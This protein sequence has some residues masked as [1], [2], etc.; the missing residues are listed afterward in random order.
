MVS[1][2]REYFLFF[3]GI[4]IHALS[5]WS[6]GFL[7]HGYVS[8]SPSS[9]SNRLSDSYDVVVV[10]SGI[11]GLSAAAMLGKYGYKV[12]VL[13]SHYLPGGAAH[14]FEMKDK[15]N[16][17]FRF[18]T[19][20]S[21]FS[22]LNPDIPAKASNPMRTV[23]DAI[24]ER[25]ECIP[26]DSFG[27]HFPEGNFIHTTNFVNEV[28]S[29]VSGL[30][31][32][33]QWQRLMR[34]MKPLEAA[35]AAMPTAA[36]RFDPG[37]V[38]SAGQFMP[39]FAFIEGGPFTTSKLTTAFESI[40]KQ[41][42][43]KDPFVKN[44][45]DLLCFCLSGLPAQGTI[46]AEMAMMMGEFYEPGALMDCPIGGAR[47]IV[48]ALIRGIEKY[49]GSV[50]LNSHV[51]EIIIEEG[52]ATGVRLKGS[53]GKCINANKGVI[54]NLSVWDLFGSGIIEKKAFPEK[55][56]KERLETPVGKSFMHLHVA[57]KATKEELENLQAHYMY[58]DDWNRGVEA[59]DN[60]GL[61]SIP[62]V[63]DET[64]APEGF[65]VLHM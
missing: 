35:V 18:D 23:L 63:H 32:S 2:T 20:P 53:S 50:I 5:C 41:S 7:V 11:G 52:R 33:K 1:R 6:S 22:G 40:L 34:D 60:A 48:E 31:G 4:I 61:I 27:L 57:F 13:E 19:G 8:P 21:F 17:V 64:L 16:R 43:V 36:L 51:D 47:S 65:G 59:E 62:S 29:K 3:S 46:T 37:V 28:I 9:R 55:F 38:L 49:G 56:V 14:G 54:S 39:N 58:I 26:Y 42:G 25:V 45:V 12:C 24:D 30:E 15:E 10:G 44:W